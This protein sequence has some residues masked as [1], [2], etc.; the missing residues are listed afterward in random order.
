MVK[1]DRCVKIVNKS[2][3]LFV[4]HREPMTNRIARK[5]QQN[6]GAAQLLFAPAGNINWLPTVAQN[7]Y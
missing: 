3:R 4:R 5:K 7:L 2:A 1:P 6:S